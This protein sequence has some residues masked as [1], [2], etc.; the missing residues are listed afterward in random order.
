ML[1][2]PYDYSFVELCFVK[3]CFVKICFVKN[4]YLEQNSSNDCI[5]ENNSSLF[6]CLTTESGFENTT[7]QY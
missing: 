5:N 7:K 4:N 2:K 1:T 3:L 6:S